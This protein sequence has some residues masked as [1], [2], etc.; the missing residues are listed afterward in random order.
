MNW[1]PPEPRPFGERIILLWER[2]VRLV[3]C[4]AI[5]FALSTAV[6]IGLGAAVTDNALVQIL[7]TALAALAFWIPLFFIVLTVDQWFARLRSKQRGRTTGNEAAGGN[8]RDD[9]VW[10]RL[11]AVAPDEK[12]RLEVI[13]R[14]LE[15]SRQSLGRAELDP[16]AHELCI[17]IDRRLP[18]LIHHELEILPPGDRDRRQKVSELIDLVEQFARH[19]SRSSSNDGVNLA[20][21]AEVLRRR[22]ETHLTEL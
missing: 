20:F 6:A 18:D 14:S 8:P 12:Q 19:C 7:V 11:S 3:M 16:A 10:R 1:M 22:F 2:G 13:R 17:L 4:S 15:R 9:H 5:A 21:E